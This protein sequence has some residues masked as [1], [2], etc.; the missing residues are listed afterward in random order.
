MIIYYQLDGKITL[1][2]NK[3]N[4]MLLITG[5]GTWF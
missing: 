2:V 4:G 3:D 1:V 5:I